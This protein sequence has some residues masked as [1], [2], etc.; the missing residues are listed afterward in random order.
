MKFGKWILS[1]FWIKVISLFLAVGTW[2][3]VADLIENSTEKKILAK[4]LPTYTKMVSKKLN[5]EAVFAGS[6]PDGYVL[7]LNE[8]RV[9]PPYLV[10]AGPRFIFNKVQKLETVPIDISEYRKISIYQA[11]IAPISKSVDTEKL[12]VSVTIPIRKIDTQKT[13]STEHKPEVR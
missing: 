1:N 2:F 6:L 13:S 11:Q 8:V 10:V 12:Q 3:Y 4:I 7:D 5:I 9:D